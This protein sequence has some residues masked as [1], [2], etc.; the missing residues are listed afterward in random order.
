MA[1]DYW[2]REYGQYFTGMSTLGG[3]IKASPLYGNQQ[4]KDV[5]F[6]FGCLGEALRLSVTQEFLVP[7]LQ[8]AMPHDML[9]LGFELAKQFSIQFAIIGAGAA[10]GATIGG[11]TGTCTIPLVGTI[12]GAGSG[13][14]LGAS[15]ASWLLLGIGLSELAGQGPYIFAAGKDEMDRGMDWAMKGEARKGASE[16]ADCFASMLAVII[17]LLL[18]AIIAKGCKGIGGFLV[19][20]PAMV[21]YL[22]KNLF[23]PSMYQKASGILGYTEEEI[24]A[25]VQISRGRILVARGCNPKRLEYIKAN[26]HAKP[27]AVHAPWNTAKSGPYVGQ[28]VCDVAKSGEAL[29]EYDL[30]AVAGTPGKFQLV[31]KKNYNALLEGHYVEQ[32][33]DNGVSKYRLLHRDGKPF[34]GDIDR[35]LFAEF[36]TGGNVKVGAQW[37]NDDPREV[38]WM[39]NQIRSRV[40]NPVSFNV[41]QHGHA[42]QNLVNDAKTG[43]PIPGWPSRTPD[44]SWDFSD[45]PLMVAVNGH[46]YIMDWPQFGSFCR[47]F[48]QTGLLFPWT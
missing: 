37:K 29:A 20:N 36:T 23:T 27:V 40:N 26:Y 7:A 42:W 24:K 18:V 4:F 3:N 43:K 44:G 32:Y 21:Q 2:E 12:A 48:Q 38:A 14:A 16:F 8:K 30:K 47:A 35:V 33:M 39:N 28:V 5:F 13:A 31:P 34:T 45:E 25:Y 46:L 15:I 1:D 22:E 10:V 41:F 9:V 6:H 17:P 19:R 11:L